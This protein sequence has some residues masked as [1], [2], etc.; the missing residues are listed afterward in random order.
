MA[1]QGGFCRRKRTFFELNVYPK[2]TDIDDTLILGTRYF[3]SMVDTNE[4]RSIERSKFWWNHQEVKALPGSV[5][6]MQ[7]ANSL[8]IEIFYISGRFNDVKAITINKLKQL[9][10]PVNSENHVILQE[11]KNITLSKEEKRQQIMKMGYHPLMLFG[12]QLDD[13]GE[14]GKGLYPEKK[15]W[16]NQHQDKFGSQWFILPNTVYGFWEE[17]ISKNYRK[18][19]PEEKHQVR[20]QEIN[21][22]NLP[23]PVPE[24]YLQHIVMADLWIRKSAD[25]NATAL[26]TYNLASK[27]LEA[28]ENRY[29]NNRAI[30]VDIDGTLIDYPPLHLTPPLCKTFPEPEEKMR[31]YE[32]QLQLSSIPGARA[33]LNKAAALGYE[34]FYVTAREHS[35]GRSGHTGDVESF[36]LK[37]LAYHG[38]PKVTQ[39]NLLNRSKYCPAN[40]K[41]CNK[42]YQR[43]AIISGQIDGKKYN[44]RLFVG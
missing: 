31:I 34:I 37:Q 20:I 4:S 19:S 2:I 32:Q 6:F 41:S 11:Q 16:V 13:L 1:V 7:K 26:Q 15:S 17:A 35:S 18:L 22:P 43:K 8:G 28:A 27:V 10:Y 38:F 44:V 23:V 33:F 12:D 42:E 29:A 24:S 21:Y 14:A 25:F 39:T 3:T 9:G 5:D 40:K 30:I 36:T